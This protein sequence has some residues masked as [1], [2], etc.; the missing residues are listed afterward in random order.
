MDAL[1]AMLTTVGKCG[2]AVA[3]KELL[4]ET[5]YETGY[6]STVYQPGDGG[7]GLIHMIPANWQLN[8][9]DMDKLFGD[10]GFAEKAKQMGKSFFQSSQYGWLSVAAWYKSTNRVAA[11]DCGVDLF[12][13]PY[14][15]QTECI[16]GSPM[17]RSETLKVATG[18]YD[19]FMGLNATIV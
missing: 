17:D 2:D 4:G 18:C 10:Q 1:N 12:D 14:N 13:A 9:A 3:I 19:K 7:A 15:K 5:S 8:A 11:D 16:L 6:F